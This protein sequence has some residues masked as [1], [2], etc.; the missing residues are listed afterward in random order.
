MRP[1]AYRDCGFESCQGHGC[2]SLVE[3]CV[4]SGR[5]VCFRLVTLPEEFYRLWCV[6]VWSWILN[7]EE[8]LAHWGLYAML[9]KVV[10]TLQLFPMLS[11]S[12]SFFPFP[13]HTLRFL[14]LVCP[15]LEHFSIKLF[16]YIPKYNPSILK[17]RNFHSCYRHGFYRSFDQQKN[18]V[19]KSKQDSNLRA[20]LCLLVWSCALE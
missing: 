1:L 18:Q 17:P 5:G 15:T 16:I 11:P 9:K 4:L 6:W 3:C 10:N 14:W 20:L 7:N 13:S 2:L 12:C 19:G 8:A